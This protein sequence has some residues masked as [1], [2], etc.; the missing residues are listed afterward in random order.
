MPPTVAVSGVKSSRRYP[1][2]H[3]DRPSRNVDVRKLIDNS[4]ASGSVEKCQPKYRGER[5]YNKVD[6]CHHKGAKG[7]II[8]F[9]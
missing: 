5:A 9:G 6:A 2:E 1:D 7:L 8:M 3:D 4:D